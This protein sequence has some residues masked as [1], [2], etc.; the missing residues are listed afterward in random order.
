MLGFVCVLEVESCVMWWW[1]DNDIER[2]VMMKFGWGRWVVWGVVLVVVVMFGV[3][4][5]DDLVECNW[6]FG[7]V[8]GSVC[9]MVYDGVSDDLLMVGFGKMGF[10]VVSVFGFVNLVWLISVELCCFVIWL[11]Y[12]VF[13]DM[14]VNGG[15]GCFW[16]L[17]VDFDGND[18]FG[19]GKIVGIEYFVYVDDGSGRKNVMLFV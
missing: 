17:N 6:L 15:Y 9:M 19:E 3:C 12:C 10:V 16:G 7:F 5:G 13:V 14:S 4:N 2:V 18:M 8:V 1:I 11:N